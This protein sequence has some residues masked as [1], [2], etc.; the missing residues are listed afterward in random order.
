VISFHQHKEYA[1]RTLGNGATA[2]W[3]AKNLDETPSLEA[4]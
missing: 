2:Q 4:F 1:V 3:L